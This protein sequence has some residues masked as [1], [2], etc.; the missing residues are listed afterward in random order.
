MNITVGVL[1]FHGD[2]IEH[3]KATQNAV[4]NLRFSID[5]IPVR[6]KEELKKC[7]ALIMPGGESTTLAKLCEREDM[8]EG[9]KRVPFLFGTCAG[10]ILLAKH[11]LHKAPGQKTLERMDITV[12]RNA[13]GRQT[14]SFEKPIAT[15]LGKLNAVF[16]RAPK[17]TSVGKNVRVLAKDEGNIL[18]C[19]EKVGKQYFLAAAFH[20]EMTTTI[21]HQYFLRKVRGFFVKT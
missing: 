2:V 9:M 20:P 13:Y 14:E 3:I 17:I 6:T 4:K 16:I 1:A 12:D 18:A 21:F 19:E 15:S 7:Q 8:F 11:V 5:V 10:A